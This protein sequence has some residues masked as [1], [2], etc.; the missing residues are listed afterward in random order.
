VTARLGAGMIEYS[1]EFAEEDG[2]PHQNVIN[3]YLR[4][5]VHR[6]KSPAFSW[7]EKK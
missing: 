6:G 2:I 1:T 4:E 5:C 7:A 3:L